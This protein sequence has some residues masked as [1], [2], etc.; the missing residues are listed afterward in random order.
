MID[1]TMFDDKYKIDKIPLVTFKAKL[2][3]SFP[4]DAE[5]E[6]E[7]C[8]NFFKIALPHHTYW[9][10]EENESLDIHKWIAKIKGLC[11]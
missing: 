9:Y 11:R 2:I 8:S 1:Y 6:V 3:K 4:S 10:D 5:F 7:I